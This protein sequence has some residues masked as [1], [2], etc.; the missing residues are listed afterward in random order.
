MGSTLTSMPWS[1]ITRTGTGRVSTRSKQEETPLAARII[2]VSDAFDAMTTDRTYRRGMSREAAMDILPR[3]CA[4]TQFDPRV[5]EAFAAL[6]C[7]KKSRPRR[8]LEP[9]S[10]LE[11]V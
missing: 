5:V 7:R 10:Q 6:V 9:E 4:G 3:K 2:H 8:E 1:C 11:T